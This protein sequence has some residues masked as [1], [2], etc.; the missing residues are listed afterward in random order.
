M[1]QEP[2][3]GPSPKDHHS[4]HHGTV[5]MPGPAGKLK[6]LV[7]TVAALLLLGVITWGT[8]KSGS[9]GSAARERPQDQ[10]FGVV[11]D[12]QGT[13]LAGAEVTGGPGGTVRSDRDGHFPLEGGGV[14]TARLPG[15]LGRAAAGTPAFPPQIRL[16]PEA[17]AVSL[18]FGG[19]VMFG[20]RY[21]EPAGERAPYLQPGASAEDHARL[22]AATAP[23]LGD[24]DLTVVN[25]ETPLVKD[26]Y[27]PEGR[28]PP[29][30]HP[31]KGIAF[32]SALESA[33]ALRQSGIDLVTL[34]NNHVADAFGLGVQ[35]TIAALDEAG[36]VHVGAGSNADEAWKPALVTVR[37]RTLAFI[38]C[39]T[40]AG[41]PGEIPYVAGPDTPGAAEC[42]PDRLQD[43][44]RAALTTADDAVV[45]IHGGTEFNREGAPHIQNL[46]Q[47]AQDAGARVVVNSHPHVIGGLLSSPKGIVA[48]SMG[49]LLFDQKIWQTLLGYLLRVEL[50]AEAQVSATTDAIA[51][52]DFIPRPAVGPMA[53][54]SARIAAGTAPGETQLGR[55]GA[56]A[57]TDAPATPTVTRES[58]P[59]DVQRLAPGWWVS[60]ADPDTRVGQDLIWGT[61]DF[62][63]PGSE[64]IATPSR[65]WAL[66]QWAKVS[67]S[68]A[69]GDGLGVQ[70]L[71]SPV[72]VE[73]VFVSTAHR[74]QVSAG[75]A[76]TL[77]AEI[78][79]ATPGGSI[80]LSWYTRSQGPSLTGIQVNIPQS[81]DDTACEIVR[82]D[83]TVPEGVV[84]AQPFLRLAPPGSETL[85]SSLY[86]DNIRLIQWA[87]PGAS[88]RLYDTIE[89]PTGS[90]A[91]FTADPAAGNNV[92]G[93]VFESFTNQV[94][95]ND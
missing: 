52:Q 95:A 94:H 16:R 19:D 2:G 60:A 51:L 26:P 22:L 18:R 20:R 69:C 45:M 24:S 6:V 47:K 80:E 88:G 53:D 72:S 12:I 42:E 3:Q 28:R 87:Q 81:S 32:G 38:S 82:I 39:T 86:V 70:L 54:S 61:G 40:V 5:R 75:Q 10:N 4:N 62:E 63:D 83:A 57:G 11:T 15:Y 85:S 30:F 43:V 56:K 33:K 49:N 23:L 64:N 34:G 91:E 1:T 90:T 76:L 71:R 37:D 84:A 66:G 17:G 48:Q 27:F 41:K 93:P 29:T 14:Y 13:P 89:A 58:P 74:Q 25:L 44:T 78:R 35:S 36:I 31:T 68:G 73:E 9:T 8:L 67:P 7:A 79:G 46:S 59:G 50:S 55:E 77:I 21:Y 92:P 65:M